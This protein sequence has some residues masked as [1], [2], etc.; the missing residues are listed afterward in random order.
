M[1]S[2]DADVAAPLV[3]ALEGLGIDVRL[4]TPLESVEDGAVVAGGE[5]IPADVVVLGLGVGPERRPGGRG[6]PRRWG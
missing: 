3:G 2:L 4:E 1:P 6:G 5:R